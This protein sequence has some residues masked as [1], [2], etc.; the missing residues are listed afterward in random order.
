MSKTK[1]PQE[2]KMLSLELDR[3]NIY[4]ENAKSSRKNIP[5]SKQLSHQ[6]ERRAGNTPL[7]AI[8]GVVDEDQALKA[9]LESRDRL[10]GKKRVAFVKRPDRPLGEVR[11]KKATRKAL[12]QAFGKA[13][14]QG[15]QSSP[16]QFRTFD[17]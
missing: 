3:R 2:K 17:T 10:I 6:S 7:L 5:K 15:L 1:S 13:N 9:E 12:V 14:P 11:R 16:I 8:K 4:G